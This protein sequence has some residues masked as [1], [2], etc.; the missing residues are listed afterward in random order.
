MKALSIRSDYAAEIMNG[1]KTE[2]YRTWS[3][4]HRGELLICNTAKKIHGF[5]PGYA[6]C[7]VRITD[8]EQRED[9]EGRYYAWKIAPF[10][11]NGSYWIEP[12]PIKGRLGLFNVD[13]RLI[14]RA[15]FTEI[16]SRNAKEWFERVIAPLR[17]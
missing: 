12:L 4:K 11:R 17:Y 14:K 9:D 6:L 3:T 10:T 16:H 2:E 13:D 7:V 15:P 8:I 5:V 1:T